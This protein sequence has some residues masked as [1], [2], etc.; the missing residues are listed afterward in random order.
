[1]SG[2]SGPVV[3]MLIA[4]V[5]VFIRLHYYSN[6]NRDMDLSIK[7]SKLY[8]YIYIYTA[9]K[10]RFHDSNIWHVSSSPMSCWRLEGNQDQLKSNTLQIRHRE[11]PCFNL[12]IG[13]LSMNCSTHLLP[14]VWQLRSFI[15]CHQ[16]FLNKWLQRWV[17]RFGHEIEGSQPYQKSFWRSWS[18][19]KAMVG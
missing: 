3:M 14:I 10:N 4:F 17:F 6:S 9:Y 13:V 11:S 19:A 2:M 8:R 15:G 12:C 7:L 16:Q 1:M 5:Y 18:E